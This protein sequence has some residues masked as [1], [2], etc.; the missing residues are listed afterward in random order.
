VAVNEAADPPMEPRGP[1]WH[2]V[3]GHADHLSAGQI[4]A[5]DRQRELGADA[6]RQLIKLLGS[7]FPPGGAAWRRAPA[8]LARVVKPDGVVLI[9]PGLTACARRTD[10]AVELA[11][12]L[13][14]GREQ[15]KR[16]D[17]YHRSQYGRD[18][19]GHLRISG[20]NVT[21]TAS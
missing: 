8:E 19:P 3:P 7:V 15:Y 1:S 13:N 18:G 17:L 4:A 21:I 11:G 20:V 16:C 14:V 9:A 6:E 5:H 10:G 12:Q 2:F